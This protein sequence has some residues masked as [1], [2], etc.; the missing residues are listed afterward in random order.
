MKRVRW[1]LILLTVSAV[2]TTRFVLGSHQAPTLRVGAAAVN[3]GADDSMVIGGGITPRYADRQEG[4]LRAVAVVLEVPGQGKA[5]IVA[6]DVLMLTRDLL[7]PIVATLGRECEIPSECILINATHTH[8][9]PSTVTVHGYARNEIFCRRV[10]QAILSAVRAASSNMKDGCQFLFRL[11]EEATIG[12][13]SRL[14]LSDGTIY[15]TGPHDDAVRTTGPVDPQLPVCSFRDPSDE[16]VAVLYNH[17]CH[18]I[19]TRLARARSPSFYGL[20]AQELESELGGTFAFLEG[21]SGSTHNNGMRDRVPIE[22]AIQRVKQT[23]RHGIE[24]GQPQRVERLIGIKRP[25]SFKVR[26]F[27]EAREDAAVSSYCEKRNPQNAEAII[28]VFRRQREVLRPLQGQSRETWLQALAVG[29][30]VFVGVPAEYFTVLGLEI[31]RR[32]PFANTYIAELANDWIG[33]LP[34]REAHRLGGYQTWMGLHSYAEP[35]TGER[36]VEQVV[37]MLEELGARHR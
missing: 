24:N 36:V 16:L 3:I 30:V 15:W 29:D 26:T 32:S 19:G 5:V 4:Q 27:D 17:S 25:F 12:Q 1:L 28:E 21:A 35:G 20:A 9:A 37:E 13:N 18:T 2:G 22:E 33:Y 7:D 10:Q 6:C 31:K 11:E 14:L 34:D 8:S 23:V